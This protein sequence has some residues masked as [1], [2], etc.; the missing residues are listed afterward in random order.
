MH[1]RGAERRL[2]SDGVSLVG[3]LLGPLWLAWHRA[4]L[5]ALLLLLAEL[6]V[7]RVAAY[8]APALTT[9]LAVTLCVATGLFGQD[10]RRWE[11]TSAG[12]RLVGIATG[13]SVS[14]ARL[15]MLELGTPRPGSQA[16][17]GA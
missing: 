12:Y 3:L 2:V 16:G 5:A 13:A 1:Q 8:G 10:W 9:A 11:L 14:D 6:L 17:P 7:W 4:L 15:R